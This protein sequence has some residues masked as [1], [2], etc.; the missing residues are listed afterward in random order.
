MINRQLGQPCEQSTQCA[1]SLC[2][3]KHCAPEGFSYIPAGTFTRG[4]PTTELGHKST[5]WQAEVG[6]HIL[7]VRMIL[8]RS[9]LCRILLFNRMSQFC[10]GSNVCG[11]PTVSRSHILTFSHAEFSRFCEFLRRGCGV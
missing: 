8:L 11:V 7:V 3:N 1:S 9:R 5:E 10:G 2:S 4:T 6:W